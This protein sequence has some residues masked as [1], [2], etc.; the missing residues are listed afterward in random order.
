MTRARNV[1]A[2]ALVLIRQL[3]HVVYILYGYDEIDAAVDKVRDAELLTVNF[4]RVHSDNLA[5]LA[6]DEELE[7]AR[8]KAEMAERATEADSAVDLEFLVWLTL[9]AENFREEMCQRLSR[10]RFLLDE[11]F[12]N[13]FIRS[14]W[15]QF[16]NEIEH[17]LRVASQQCGVSV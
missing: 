12:V 14:V 17:T 13:C 11:V 6:L 8:I 15:K 10:R 5:L 16:Q 2:D 1:K 9:S 7:V 4:P 3:R